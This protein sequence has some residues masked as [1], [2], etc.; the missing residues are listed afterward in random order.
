MTV[1]GVA[2]LLPSG[3]LDPS[4]TPTTSN[5]TRTIFRALP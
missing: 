4:F 2:R 1:E 3:A 5:T